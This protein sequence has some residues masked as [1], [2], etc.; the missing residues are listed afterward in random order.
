M[1]N[2]SSDPPD[3]SPQTL[4]DKKSLRAA[5]KLRRAALATDHRR[6][7]ATAIA[8]MDWASLIG[9]PPLIVAAFRSMAEEL[10]TGP[11]L[12]RLAFLGYRLCLPVMQGRLQPL[13]FRAWAPGDAMGTAVWGIEEP[14]PDKTVLEP[15]V[16]LAPLLAFD[17]RG[18][19]LGY[20][21]GF[22]DLTLRAARPRKPVRVI[23][24][25]FSEQEVDA[26]PL[27]DYD[28]RLDAVLTP[29][30]LVESRA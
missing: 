28:E 16:I 10:D 12:D 11:L 4:S 6:A 23:G 22:Y 25:A 14:T 30:G 21:G 1:R 9:P 5:A 7:G 19:R 20:G 18:G 2:S 29:D 13:L 8:A 3:S 27:L 24:L 17:R 26:V 15:D